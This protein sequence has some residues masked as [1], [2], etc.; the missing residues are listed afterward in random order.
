MKKDNFP[1]VYTTD[2]RGDKSGYNFVVCADKKFYKYYYTKIEKEEYNKK[3]EYP[4]LDEFILR[5][6]YQKK[7]ENLQK[8]SYATDKN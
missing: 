6:D 3:Q 4:N 1:I 2:T 7:I 8:N 5:E